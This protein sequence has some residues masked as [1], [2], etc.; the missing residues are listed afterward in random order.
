MQLKTWYVEEIRGVVLEDRH[1][2]NDS[3]PLKLGGWRPASLRSWG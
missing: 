1:L 2:W 3:H